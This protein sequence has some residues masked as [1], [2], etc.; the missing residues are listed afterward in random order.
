M[1]DVYTC[2]GRHYLSYMS[3]AAQGAAPLAPSKFCT[4][5]SSSHACFGL[6][7]PP[8]KH[9]ILAGTLFLA[10]QQVLEAIQLHLSPGSAEELMCDRGCGG[11]V[12]VLAC[13]WS[14]TG[15]ATGARKRSPQ[16]S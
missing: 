5:E 7:A 3:K 2:S 14:V 4:A 1:H 6:T 10:Q 16:V 13:L 12:L 11:I 9:F 8:V 15:F